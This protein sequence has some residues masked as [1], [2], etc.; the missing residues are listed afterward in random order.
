[1]SHD[2]APTVLS[3]D[4]ATRQAEHRLRALGARVTQPRVRVLARL[5]ASPELLSHQDVIE[6]LPAGAEAMDRVTV[7]RVLDW[8]AEQGL[9]QKRAGDD[10]VYRFGLSDHVEAREMAHRSHGHF[11]C[12]RC[13]RVFCLEDCMV[14]AAGDI[15]QPQLPEGFTVDHVELTVKGRCPDCASGAVARVPHSH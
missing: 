10:R 12:T 8:L 15:P 13:E 1:M 11:Q 2:P 14:E 9:A 6:G 5:I 7:Y 3:D 4:D